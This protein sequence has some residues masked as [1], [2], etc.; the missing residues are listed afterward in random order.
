MRE[1]KE[2]H[3]AT[4]NLRKVNAEFSHTIAKHL[5]KLRK[6]LV[7]MLQ[8]IPRWQDFSAN[9]FQIYSKL[10]HDCGIVI[11]VAWRDDVTRQYHD[12]HFSIVQV[13]NAGL[14]SA[15]EKI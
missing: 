6:D 14:L 10:D 9:E 3:S 12:T 11:P 15:K 5:R 1:L 7:L 13:G 4:F 2:V 8:E